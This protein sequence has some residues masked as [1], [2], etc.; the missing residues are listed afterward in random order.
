LDDICGSSASLANGRGIWETAIED[1]FLWQVDD[2][3]IELS[4][5]G[6]TLFIPRGPAAR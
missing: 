3:E 5:P 6:G 1:L 4:A 2:T